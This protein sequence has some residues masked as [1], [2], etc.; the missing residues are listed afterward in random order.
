MKKK[1]SSRR[2]IEVN[3]EELDRL[4]DSS[5]RAPL[6]E[7]DANKLKT[8][9]HAMA[10]R[11]R[12]KRN[13]EKTGKVLD[14]PVTVPPEKERAPDETISPGH[15]RNSAAAFTGVHRREQSCDCARHAA[16]RRS[17]SG[18]PA[19]KSLSSEGTCDAAA[20]HGASA[21]ERDCV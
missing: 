14:K 8:V 5:K 9:L 2:Q 21:I 18:M 13:T 20:H 16:L 19:G 12:P 3:L 11:L 4:I 1:S 15:G 10:E 7:C 17:L 6:S